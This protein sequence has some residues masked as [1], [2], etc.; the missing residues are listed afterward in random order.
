VGAGSWGWEGG[1]VGWGVGC[2]VGTAVGCRV[3]IGV[4]VGAGMSVGTGVLVKPSGLDKAGEGARKSSK[5]I[6][7]NR[8]TGR[9]TIIF[10]I[11][12]LRGI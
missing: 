12:L 7:K 8:L 9:R 4:S 1:F 3:G 5:A 10:F 6:A 2:S 11:V